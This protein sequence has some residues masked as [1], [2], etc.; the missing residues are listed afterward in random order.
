[1]ESIFGFFTSIGGLVILGLVGLMIIGYIRLARSSQK[2]SE[3]T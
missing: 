2:L 3:L 1:M